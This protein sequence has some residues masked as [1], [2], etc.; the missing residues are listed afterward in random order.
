MSVEFDSMQEYAR[1]AVAG[2]FT[3][4][5]ITDVQNLQVS[6]IFDEQSETDYFTIT[7][8]S[9][10]YNNTDDGGVVDI[11]L[12]FTDGVLTTSSGLSGGIPG[13]DEA[14]FQQWYEF[15]DPDKNDEYALEAVES[16]FTQVDI[17]DDDWVQLSASVEG[18][19]TGELI[20]IEADSIEM[21]GVQ[22]Y[23]VRI[24]L[25]FE[26]GTL[27]S[28]SGIPAAM[29]G[30]LNNAY[31]QTWY[32][33]SGPDKQR[34]DDQQDSGYYDGDESYTEIYS[35]VWSWE[36]YDGVIWTVVDKEENGAWS[37][38]ETG[39]NG[40]VRVHSSSWDPNTQISTW[41]ETFHNSD[42][43]IN[44]T[45]TETQNPDGTSSARLTG[46][47]DHLL[48]IPLD[49]IYTSVDVTETRDAFWNT[50][51]IAG[52]VTNPN[53]EVLAVT[54][55]SDGEILV[56]GESMFDVGGF[57]DHFQQ[58]N[59]WEWTDEWSGTTWRV[60]EESDVDGKWV[61]TETAYRDDDGDG[62]A[63]TATGE[64][65]SNWSSWDESTQESTW[66]ESY[67][68]ED[69]TIDFQRVETW[70]DSD[71]TS[72]ETIT[73]SNDHI[74][75]YYL[76][77]VYTNINVTV[78][79]DAN[80]NTTSI[81]GSVMKDGATLIVSFDDGDILI[82]GESL[83]D[84]DERD[85]NFQDGGTNEWSWTDWDDV[86]WTVTDEQIGN[87]WTSTEIGSNG[88][89]RVHKNVWDDTTNSSTMTEEFSSGDG[90]VDYIR[91][92][93]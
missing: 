26:N 79:R 20:T 34:E 75:W 30:V 14:S 62:T 73:G 50:I 71:G 9:F 3:H 84:M 33:Y 56:G 68:S 81:S 93:E 82:D 22:H 11:Q 7:A 92:E 29:S 16:L 74:A 52:T 46:S 69:G 39:S 28:D 40:D 31:I 23:A 43:S 61:M 37:S 76:G 25:T 80:W 5:G 47:I 91:E 88:D 19:E 66:S 13:L 55:S 48:W 67:R 58:S 17:D 42:S 63:E 83:D 54:Y 57:D 77:D 44:Y 60:V 45:R 35:N 18:T 21:D 4:I 78:D 89:Q 87:T 70:N 1:E 64:M 27:T 51:N 38:T 10:T 53:S 65:R 36:D 2:F 41:S 49:G 72:S 32:D 6:V 85:D 90:R 15:F 86:T 59:E 8:D 12:T 24:V